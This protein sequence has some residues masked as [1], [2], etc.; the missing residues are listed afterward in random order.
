MLLARS[1]RARR[2]R[3]RLD[4]RA[5]TTIRGERRNLRRSAHADPQPR[6]SSPQR[7]PGDL[8]HPGRRVEFFGVWDKAALLAARWP[9]IAAAAKIGRRLDFCCAAPAPRR[10]FAGAV[11]GK[12]PAE[13]GDDL[14][15][16]ALPPFRAEQTRNTEPATINPTSTPPDASACR[17]PTTGIGESGGSVGGSASRLG[18]ECGNLR[19]WDAITPGTH[20]EGL[21]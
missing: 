3:S 20:G 10:P 8:V 11:K 14:A 6:A 17:S 18:A 2:R 21:R 15:G 4:C 9:A 12:K 1:G 5:C 16:W 19:R 7:S 13:G